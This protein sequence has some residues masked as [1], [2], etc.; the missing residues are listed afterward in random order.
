[1]N[2][3]V[4]LPPASAQKIRATFATFPHIEKA[5]LFGSRAKGTAKPG[6]DIDLALNRIDF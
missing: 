1:M 4:T 5:V 2:D 6:S 3:K